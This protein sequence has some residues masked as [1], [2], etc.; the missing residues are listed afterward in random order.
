M[1]LLSK[2]TDSIFLDVFLDYFDGD[3]ATELL[4]TETSGNLVTEN[5]VAYNIT[6][7]F[8]SSY[9]LPSEQDVQLI[10]DREFAPFSNATHV[11]MERLHSSGDVELSKI[12]SVVFLSTEGEVKAF[13]SFSDAAIDPH[14]NE[15][16]KDNVS[17]VDGAFP[18][19]EGGLGKTDTVAKIDLMVLRA[20]LVSSMIFFTLFLV[21]LEARRQNALQQDDPD[22]N[23]MK[24]NPGHEKHHTYRT[25]VFSEEGIN[26]SSWKKTNLED[27]SIGDESQSVTSITSQSPPASPKHL[28]DRVRPQRSGG[29]VSKPAWTTRSRVTS[30]GHTSDEEKSPLEPDL[31]VVPPATQMLSIPSLSALQSKKEHIIDNSDLPLPAEDGSEFSCDVGGLP[32]DEDT[33]GKKS[34][35]LDDVLSYGEQEDGDVL[36]FDERTDS[37]GGNDQAEIQQ[38]PSPTPSSGSNCGDSHDSPEPEWMKKFKEMGLSSE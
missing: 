37:T 15:T 23:I 25:S 31:Q 32:E 13:S 21:Y 38:S 14:Q 33:E 19:S 6:L 18:S 10:A 26:H 17:R 28:L 8:A 35:T 16:E 2:A 34:P 29:K 5:V 1:R 7:Y 12:E 27:V 11:Y 30:F 3:T 22:M 24:P 36:S 9:A 4:S 20:V